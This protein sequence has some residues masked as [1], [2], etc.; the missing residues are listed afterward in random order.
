MVDQPEFREGVLRLAARG[1]SETP[2]SNP[3]FA[4][5]CHPERSQG[6]AF[7]GELQIPGF[8]RDDNSLEV[9]LVHRSGPDFH[10]GLLRGAARIVL[11]LLLTL[12][13][14]HGASW[15]TGSPPAE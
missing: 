6:S 11:V 13:L 7:C 8:A 1:E 12:V 10:H 3:Q 14:A 9:S 15:A 5:L 2:L 4:R